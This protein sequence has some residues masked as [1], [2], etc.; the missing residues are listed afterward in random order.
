MHL[1]D[2]YICKKVCKLDRDKTDLILHN[3]HMVDNIE[4]GVMYAAKILGLDTKKV[5]SIINRIMKKEY[6]IKSIIQEEFKYIIIDSEDKS[7]KIPIRLENIPKDKYVERYLT[8][9]IRPKNM[10]KVF[11]GFNKMNA[12]DTEYIINILANPF[13]RSRHPFCSIS[14]EDKVLG[15]LGM[16]SPSVLKSR[17]TNILYLVSDSVDSY[18]KHITE[19]LTSK[20]SVYIIVLTKEDISHH[21]CCVKHKKGLF[22]VKDITRDESKLPYLILLSN[23]PDNNIRKIDNLFDV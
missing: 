23:R 19:C 12:T 6:K 16:L 17:M 14:N 2:Y 22:E 11:N 1:G 20:E 7:F 10:F 18:Y 4:I 21:P 3:V 9:D 8:Y 15:S 5:K 13:I